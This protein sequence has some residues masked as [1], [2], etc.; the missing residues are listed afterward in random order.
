MQLSEDVGDKKMQKNER[1]KRARSKNKRC[2]KQ[3]Q[4]DKNLSRDDR[5]TV[6]TTNKQTDRKTDKQTDTQ[7]EKPTDRQ[8]DRHKDRQTHKHKD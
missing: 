1:E 7:A 2:A 3:I 5:Q 6:R 4:K 8:T